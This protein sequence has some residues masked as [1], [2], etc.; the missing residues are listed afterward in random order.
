MITITLHFV[1]GFFAGITAVVAV[2]ML[3]GYGARCQKI[4]DRR[5]QYA[6][7]LEEDSA[8]TPE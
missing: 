4:Q 7:W 3:I 2:L 1:H 5:R 6:E 8:D